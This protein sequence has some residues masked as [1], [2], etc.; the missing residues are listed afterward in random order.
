MYVCM[1]VCVYVCMY[2]C[3]YVCVRM[4]V[5]IEVCIYTLR[6]VCIEV[7]MYICMYVYMYVCMY[8][9]TY[10][11]TY[12]CTYVY[13]CVYVCPMYVCTY[14]YYISMHAAFLNMLQ[15]PHT[16]PL[17]QI[18]EPL[19]FSKA[20]CSYT[21]TTKDSSLCLYMMCERGTQTMYLVSRNCLDICVA[22]MFSRC[23]PVSE[24]HWYLTA[25]DEYG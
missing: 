18:N 25:G 23:S 19:G 10:V 14:M 1:Y 22:Q 13:V 15:L 17:D 16:G 20:I 24:K 12:V 6:Y 2:V 3:I 11:R 5:C 8:V 7:C 4:Y 21:S 9:L